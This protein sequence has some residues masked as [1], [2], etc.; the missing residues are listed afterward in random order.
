M[1]DELLSLRAI[2]VSGSAADH[3][4]FRQAA[5]LLSVPVEMAA[6]DGAASARRCLAQGADLVFIGDRLADGDAA[7]VAAAARA[8]DKPPFTVLLAAAAPDPLPTNGVA[9]MPA[10]REAAQQLLERVV[11]VRLPSRVL[12]VDDSA[13]MRSIV[14]KILAATRFS[15]EITEAHEGAAALKLARERAFD[16]AFIDYNMPGFTGLETLAEL[17]RE[18]HRTSVVVMTSMKDA[19]LE[20]RVRAQGAIFLRKPFFPA[21]IEALLC[22][23]YGL[24]VLNPKRG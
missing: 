1:S 7:S 12:L 16:I 20:Q 4:L 11:Q 21:E 22:G 17:K 10:H 23:H 15:F 6:A 13:T 8:T 3:D 9:A 19:A 18:R 5:S 2:L 24:S 14:R